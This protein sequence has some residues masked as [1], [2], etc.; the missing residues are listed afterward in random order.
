MVSARQH[1][2]QKQSE[3]KCGRTSEWLS[4][5]TASESKEVALVE[6]AKSH[7]GYIRLEKKFQP[8]ESG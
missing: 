4:L 7:I 6:E 8:R 5:S 3:P 2:V 1:Q